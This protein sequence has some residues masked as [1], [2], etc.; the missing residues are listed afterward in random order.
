MYLHV[1][2]PEKCLQKVWHSRN[3]KYLLTCCPSQ[4]A[5]LPGLPHLLQYLSGHRHLDIYTKG[6][7]FFHLLLVLRE[8]RYPAVPPAMMV[9]CPRDE[10]PCL[11][12]TAV[13]AKPALE[14]QNRTFF[15]DILSWKGP[16]RVQMS[17]V[18]SWQG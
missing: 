13:Q 18:S 7:T 10:Q 4:E 16:A 8:W 17:C 11:S 15:L 1:Q 12:P 6:L 5:N 3:G 9:C 2:C 14:T